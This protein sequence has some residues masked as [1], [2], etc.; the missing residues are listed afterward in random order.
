MRVPWPRFA[1]VRG[2]GAAGA[3]SRLAEQN[4]VAL[5]AVVHGFAAGEELGLPLD[6]FPARVDSECTR[7]RDELGEN[8]GD[9]TAESRRVDMNNALT[10]ERSRELL[11]MGRDVRARNGRI[12]PADSSMHPRGGGKRSC[13]AVAKIREAAEIRIDLGER[14]A[15]GTVALA[16][17]GQPVAKIVVPFRLPGSGAVRR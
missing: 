4:A 6:D 5:E 17:A 16:E 9:A 8:L 11:Q 13:D 1:P 2:D 15:G 7:E 3:Q 14:A 10:Y 12:D